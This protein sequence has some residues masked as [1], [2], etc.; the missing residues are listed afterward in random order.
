MLFWIFDLDFTLYQI[1]YGESFSYKKL[2]N[3]AQL[4]YL[5][6]KLPSQRIMFTNGTI[7]HADT[8]IQRLNL[9]RCFHNVIARDSIMDLK[10]NPSAYQKC[11]VLN[12][13]TQEDK[14]VFFE[15]SV[16]NLI[17]AKDRGWITVLIS[18]NMDNKMHENIDFYFPNIYVALNFFNSSIEN[19]FN[20]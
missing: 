15:D 10:P 17:V 5:L 8:C 20:L 13:I 7:F 11:E 18:P 16:E 12:N 6:R 1:P 19:H 3:D 4:K 14:V 9:K 2:N